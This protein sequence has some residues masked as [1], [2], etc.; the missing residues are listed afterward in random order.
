MQNTVDAA[1]QQFGELT[2]QQTTIKTADGAEVILYHDVDLTDNDIAA[3]EGLTARR[4]REALGETLTE[5]KL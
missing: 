1:K 2:G 3:L 4:L 5:K